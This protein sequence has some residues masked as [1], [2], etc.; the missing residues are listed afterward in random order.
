MNDAIRIAKMV[1]PVAR[2]RLEKGGMAVSVPDIHPL[3]QTMQTENQ[4]RVITSPVPGFQGR[5]ASEA[6]YRD[7]SIEDEKK[8]LKKWT[9]STPNACAS[10]CS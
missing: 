2:V 7:P 5:L 6:K 10:T 4:P 8:T 9:P 3:E 1:K